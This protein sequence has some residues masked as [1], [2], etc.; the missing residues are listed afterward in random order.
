M[1][2]FLLLVVLITGL[3]LQS[4]SKKSGTDDPKPVDPGTGETETLKI[5]PDSIFRVYLKANVCPNAFDQSGKRI[6]ITHP[7]VKNF[8]GTMKIDTVTCSIPYVSSLKG[9]E[10][11]TKM[12][13]LIVQLSPIDS[14]KLTSSMDLDTLRLLNTRDLQYVNISGCTN[15]RYI[16]IGDMPATSLD[17]SNLPELNYVSLISLRRLSELKIDNDP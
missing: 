5:I 12:K 4:C 6:D 10:Y 14:L 1:T 2:K 17:L 8:I 9:I 16:R 13:K 15:M 7:E 11:F 3:L